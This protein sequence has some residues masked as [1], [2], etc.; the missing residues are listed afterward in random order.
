VGPTSATRTSQ[1]RR[2][3]ARR[4][5]SPGKLAGLEK[6]GRREERGAERSGRQCASGRERVRVRVVLQSRA[7]GRS[8]FSVSGG[9]LRLRSGGGRP[10][11]LFLPCSRTFW[12]SEVRGPLCCRSD[13]PLCRLSVIVQCS[14]LVSVGGVLRYFFICIR[15]ILCCNKVAIFV[16]FITLLTARPPPIT[17]QVRDYILVAA[18]GSEEFQWGFF[19]RD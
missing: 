16:I 1:A 13:I 17:H 3:G 11:R 14:G 4:V 7:R 6:G 9:H 15:V 5:A 10:P 18:V 2:E 8:S 19:F 12:D